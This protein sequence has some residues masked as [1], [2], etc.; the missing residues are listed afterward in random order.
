MAVAS[1]KVF[2]LLISFG[3]DHLA[4]LS[5][6]FASSTNLQGFRED[7]EILKF[8]APAARGPAT[9]AGPWNQNLKPGS[10]GSKRPATQGVVVE[11]LS[12]ECQSSMKLVDCALEDRGIVERPGKDDRALDGENGVFREEACLLSVTALPDERCL[13]SVYPGDEVIP[14]SLGEE[15]S[16]VGDSQGTNETDAPARSEVFRGF[17]EHC[18]DRGIGIVSVSQGRIDGIFK[19]LL[20]LGEHGPDHL[21]LPIRE[22]VIQ[23]TLAQ[24]GG[25]ADQG[26]ARTVV[27]MLAKN[28]GQGG[29][30]VG[31]FSDHAGHD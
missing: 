16:G 29:D 9:A 7:D 26:K 28:F 4:A 3:A 31:S 18:R 5:Q 25:L 13:Q 15:V 22:E 8:A 19:P 27:S 17:I 2:I 6:R 21:L 20:D 1:R 23:T 11:R 30:G 10:E 14:D 12:I 24:A